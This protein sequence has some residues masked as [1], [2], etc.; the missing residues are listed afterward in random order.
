MLALGLF[1]SYSL[2]WANPKMPHKSIRPIPWQFNSKYSCIG[3][4]YAVPVPSG[5]MMYDTN[6]P[7]NNVCAVCWGACGCI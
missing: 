5:L 4:K 2:L 1:G 7:L 6:T 3:F